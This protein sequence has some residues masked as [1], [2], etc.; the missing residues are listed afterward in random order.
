MTVYPFPK[1]AEGPDVACLM[2]SQERMAQVIDVAVAQNGIG[3]IVTA[4]GCGKTTL[5]ERCRDTMPGVRMITASPAKATLPGMLRAICRA[6]DL[7]P[8]DSASRMEEAICNAIQW[9]MARPVLLVDEAQRYPF[10]CLDELRCIHDRMRVPLVL[11]G[12][13]SL[14]SRLN[15]GGASDYAPIASRIVAKFV[16]DASNAADVEALAAQHGVTERKAAQW[17]ADRCAG[18]GNLRMASRLLSFAATIADGGEIGLA[19]LKDAAA[20][21]GAGR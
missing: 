17:L 16:Q 13:H 21:Q 7:Y 20:V 12:N 3:L 19:H 11:A 4:Q 2:P 15:K 1:Q 8:V 18:T 5:F 10:A 14:R 6:L 9:E